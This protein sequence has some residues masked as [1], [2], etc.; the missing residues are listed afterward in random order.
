MVVVVVGS[1]EVTLDSGPASPGEHA[2]D[3]N[4]LLLVEHEDDE[5]RVLGLLVLLQ[6][7][8]QSRVP[9]VRVHDCVFERH[10]T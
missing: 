1:K 6:Q 3:A 4:G 7:L 9:R 5:L 10:I 2:L 8:V